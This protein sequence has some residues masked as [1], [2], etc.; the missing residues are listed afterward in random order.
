M[1]PLYEN[2]NS[3]KRQDKQESYSQS[4]TSGVEV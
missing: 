2:A 3:Q 1:Q 4:L